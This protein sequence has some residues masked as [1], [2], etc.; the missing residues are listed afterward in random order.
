MLKFIIDTQLPPKL[1][2]FLTEKGCDAVHTT[3]FPDG[4]FDGLH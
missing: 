3:S 2:S 1:A 4:H